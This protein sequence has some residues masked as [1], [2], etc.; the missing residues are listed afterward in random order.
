MKQLNSEL[1]G[2]EPKWEFYNTFNKPMLKRV[3]PE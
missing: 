1:Q 2:N 3:W